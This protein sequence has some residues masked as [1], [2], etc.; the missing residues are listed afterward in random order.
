V[1]TGVLS[2]P[3]ATTASTGTTATGRPY[4]FYFSNPTGNPNA[5]AKPAWQTKTMQMLARG[6]RNPRAAF[7]GQWAGQYPRLAAALG[8]GNYIQNRALRRRLP[9][10]MN[11]GRVT[12][13]YGSDDRNQ[14]PQFEEYL[15]AMGELPRPP[16]LPNYG[17]T[18]GGG[19]NYPGAEP[20]SLDAQFGPARPW[21]PWPWS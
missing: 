12:G 16:Q 20:G 19:T 3:S 18:M 4:D 2:N 5:T 21:W 17:N 1:D 8:Y 6:S 13:G 9:G 15:Q 7:M 14:A 11:P 10:G